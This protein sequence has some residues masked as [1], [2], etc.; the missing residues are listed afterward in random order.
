MLK[1]EVRG[2][3]LRAKKRHWGVLSKGRWLQEAK[4]H[5]IILNAAW[6]MSGH[7]GGGG[8]GRA[9]TCL[10]D[11]A[12]LCYAKS[13]QSCPT[14]FNPID[15]SPPGSGVLGILQARILEWVAICFSSA[16]KEKS[17]S[18]VAHSCPTLSDPIHGLKPTRL[19][20]PWD[21]PGKSTG[22]GCHCLLQDNGFH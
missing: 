22:V 15:G 4:F 2:L 12:M 10:Q 1:T 19:L 21:F 7:R 14:L 11:N 6:W 18:E 16:W 8:W 13:L 9:A 3:S 20:R 17:E 5:T